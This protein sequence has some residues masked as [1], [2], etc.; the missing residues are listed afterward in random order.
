MRIFK[1]LPVLLLKNAYVFKY[2]L[3][4]SGMLTQKRPIRAVTSIQL[5]KDIFKRFK[6]MCVLKESTMSG[7]IEEMIKRRLT[8]MEN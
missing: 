3:Q 1:Y 6:A 4:E 7:E 5:N 8:E 2:K